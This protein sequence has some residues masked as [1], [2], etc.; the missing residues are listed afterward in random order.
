LK[1]TGAALDSK[2]RDH[3]IIELTRQNKQARVLGS[4]PERVPWV[5]WE[6]CGLQAALVAQN[7]S[8]IELHRVDHVAVEQ[9]HAGDG[10]E[11]E[12]KAVEHRHFGYAGDAM[13][14]FWRRRRWRPAQQPPRSNVCEFGTQC[15]VSID[16]TCGAVSWSVLHSVGRYSQHSACVGAATCIKAAHRFLKACCQRSLSCRTPV[17]A[18]A[19]RAR[20]PAEAA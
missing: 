6:L 18:P 3:S 19:L 17:P 8:V 2:Q 15:C 4:A 20:V 13:C 11:G 1:C 7:D 16:L 5:E 12:L 9:G 14:H 10:A